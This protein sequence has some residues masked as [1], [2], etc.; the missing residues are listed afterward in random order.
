MPGPVACVSGFA[1]HPHKVTWIQAGCAPLIRL[2]D[3]LGQAARP[4]GGVGTRLPPFNRLDRRADAA[5]NELVTQPV[6][7]PE[8]AHEALGP[9]DHELDT[10][11][12]E[13]GVDLPE[14]QGAGEVELTHALHAQHKIGGLGIGG[15]HQG[16]DAGLEEFRVEK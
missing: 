3:D 11:P 8:A 14:R 16:Q 13:L 1:G 4:G 7:I 9:G 10:A 2:A 5:E 6:G 12:L 15:V